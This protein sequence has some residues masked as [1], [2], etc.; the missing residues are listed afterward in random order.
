M[1]KGIFDVALKR[2]LIK[3]LSKVSPR[4]NASGAF[5]QII[6]TQHIIRHDYFLSAI[7]PVKSDFAVRTFNA[8]FNGTKA[9]PIRGRL[10]VRKTP[11]EA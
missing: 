8:N 10:Y 9:E 6:H 2:L 1:R 7:L 4:Q 5:L 3:V 11:L